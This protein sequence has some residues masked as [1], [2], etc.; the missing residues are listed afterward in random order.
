MREATLTRPLF[1]G[2]LRSPV[3]VALYRDACSNS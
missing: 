1:L 2:L 3:L